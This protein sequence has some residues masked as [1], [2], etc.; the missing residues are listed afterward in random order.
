M[1][2]SNRWTESTKIV[3]KTAESAHHEEETDVF[4]HEH[5]LLN[6]VEIEKFVL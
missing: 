1:D 4:T 5:K 6:E 2:K 3:Q